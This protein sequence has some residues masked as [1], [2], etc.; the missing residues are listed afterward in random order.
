MD[1]KILAALAALET[2][3][4]AGISVA[5]LN[6]AAEHSKPPVGLELETPATDAQLADIATLTTKVNAI[7]RRVTATP[8]A[9]SATAAWLIDQLNDAIGSTAK[10]FHKGFHKGR[11]KGALTIKDGSKP[12]TFAQKRGCLARGV[13]PSDSWSMADADAAI[14]AAD[15]ARLAAA[16]VDS[17]F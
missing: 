16:P 8:V 7:G 11:P 9:T 5:D 4:A 3:K 12:M 6:V 10:G 17:V 13:Q 14:K 2:L 1:E 15:A